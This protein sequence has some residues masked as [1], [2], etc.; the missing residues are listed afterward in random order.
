MKAVPVLVLFA[1]LSFRGIA[2]ADN[3][4]EGN[5]GDIDKNADNHIVKGEFIHFFKFKRS[6]EEAFDTFDTDKSGHLDHDE[7]NACQ[8][9]QEQ[10]RKGKG[11]QGTPE[12]KP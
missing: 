3:A 5:F 12:K 7:W 1:L 4:Y 11:Q 6:P 9:A 2:C 8:M 10:A